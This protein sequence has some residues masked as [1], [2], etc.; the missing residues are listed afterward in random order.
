MTI[1][2]I[3]TVNDKGADIVKSMVNNLSKGIVSEDINSVVVESEDRDVMIHKSDDV[4]WINGK[5]ACILK[6][7][8][9]KG[10]SMKAKKAMLSTSTRMYDIVVE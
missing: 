5:Y 3:K 4:L 1:V 9:L 7:T 8:G 2:I 10:L 6:L